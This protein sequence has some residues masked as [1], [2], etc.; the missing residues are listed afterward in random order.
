MIAVHVA[1]RLVCPAAIYFWVPTCNPKLQTL[2]CL[3]GK[4]VAGAGCSSVALTSPRSQS[5]L[6]GEGSPRLLRNGPWEGVK[7]KLKC[8]G[9]DSVFAGEQEWWVGIYVVSL[10]LLHLSKPH[11]HG[12]G[13]PTLPALASWKDLKV[14][15]A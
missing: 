13:F 2:Y 14:S 12:L 6:H 1:N 8:F 3:R 11:V 7:G 10:E 4:E 15:K 9:S 5:I